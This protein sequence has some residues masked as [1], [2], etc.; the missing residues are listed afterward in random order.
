MTQKGQGLTN[1]RPPDTSEVD[2]LVDKIPKSPENL[3]KDFLQEFL[4]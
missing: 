2:S 1:P 3:G 4:I